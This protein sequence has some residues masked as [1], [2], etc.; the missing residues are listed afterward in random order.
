MAEWIISFGTVGIA[1]SLL[2]TV[3]SSH[4]PSLWTSLAQIVLVGAF[5]VSFWTLDLPGIAGANALVALLWS[6]IFLQTIRR[7]SPRQSPETSPEENQS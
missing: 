5:A 2:P 6:V 4:K 7:G 3:F 1:L